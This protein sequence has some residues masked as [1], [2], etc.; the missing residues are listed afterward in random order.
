MKINSDNTLGEIVSENYQA[1]AVFEKY[2]LDF[3]CHGQ[4]SLSE[5][6]QAKNLDV[7]S[8]LA[9]LDQLSER[10]T[11]NDSEQSGG[12][13][14]GL[15]NWPLDLMAD[16]VEKTHHR[17]VTKQIPVIN[18]YLDKIVQ[19]HGQRHPELATI[20][21][22]FHETAGELSMHMKKEELMLFPFIR[23]MTSA[24]INGVQI[25]PPAFGHIANPVNAMVA[26]HDAEA[27]RSA[28]IREL[29]NDYK[30]PQD[31]CNTYRL[32]FRLLQDFEA[33]LHAHLHIENNILF[34]K[35]IAL[36]PSV[37]S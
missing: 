23:K 13:P 32:S 19:V 28:R 12:V 30:A 3:C 24:S 37:L 27:E 9:E 29:C 7:E 8:I 16:Y 14:A 10:A 34:P 35:S 18:Q 5:A 11:G 15:Q 25:A 6:S 20:R 17:Y 26:D 22:I 4:R 36:E 33:D 2:Q 1:A 31:A 21:E